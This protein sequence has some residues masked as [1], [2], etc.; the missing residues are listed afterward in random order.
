MVNTIKDMVDI[1]KNL[2]FEV[3]YS[4]S[5]KNIKSMASIKI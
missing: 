1:K 2:E 4:K 5:D 3:L